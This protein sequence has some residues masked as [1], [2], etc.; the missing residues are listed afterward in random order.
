MQADLARGDTNAV[1]N[2]LRDLERLRVG[3]RPA[4]EA[5]DGP[6]LRAQLYLAIRDTAGAVRVLDGYLGDMVNITPGNFA[7]PYQPV[8][9]VRMMALR[10]ELAAQADDR[11]RARKEA[12]AALDLWRDA[13]KELQPQLRRLRSLARL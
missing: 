9:I 11:Q 10:A 12:R 7:Q 1:A 8:S 5:A 6:L 3:S 2:S 4:S 13:D